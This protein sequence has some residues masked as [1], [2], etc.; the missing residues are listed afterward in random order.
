MNR[1]ET[2]W[3]SPALGKWMRVLSHGHD[4]APILMIPTQDGMAGQY[5]ERGIPNLLGDFIDGGRIRLFTVDTVDTESWS[6]TGADPAQRAA[7][8]EAYVRYITEEVVPYIHSA[9]ASQWRPFTSGCSLGATHAA[10]L[11]L[12]RP[13]LFQGCLS[14]SGV[15][16]AQYLFGNYMDSTLY[17]NS[18]IHFIGGMSNDHPWVKLYNERKLFFCTGTGAWEDE[19][20]RS[21]GI[22]R[23]EFAATGIHGWFDFWGPDVNHDWPWWER[24][25]RYFIP[26]LL[27]DL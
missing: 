10:I 21:L 5:E 11:A 9:T 7:R 18:P 2:S 3:W 23:D 22:L 26:H 12:R 4:G 27:D 20:I 8:Q 6:A 25:Y 24:Q 14:L 13:D 1:F 19:G 15:Y 17:A 16:D